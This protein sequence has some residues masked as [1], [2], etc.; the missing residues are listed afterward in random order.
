MKM[1]FLGKTGLQVSELCLGTGNF[2]ALGIYKKAGDIGQKE[3]DDIVSMALHSGINFFNTSEAYSDGRAEETLGKAL[4][5]RRKEAIVITKVHPTRSPGPNDGG[6]S[7]KHI[8]EGCEASLKRLKTDYVDLYQLHGFDPNTPIEV[9]LRALD[10]LVREGK[11]RYI[12]CSNFKGWQLMKSLAI[13]R[14]SGWES[15]ATLEAMY[16]LLSRELEYELIPACLDQ[17]IAILAFSPLHGGFLSGKYR[18]G[19]AWPAETRFDKFES[20]GAWPV[21]QE[22]LFKIVEELD[23]IAKNCS[24]SISQV[25]LNYLLRKSGI[26]S[27]IIGVRTLKQLEE[28]INATDWQMAPEDV[29]K[30]DGISAPVRKYP[31]SIFDAKTGKSE[32]T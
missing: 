17:G 3:A 12:G 18:R 2:S 28:N 31:Y 14:E 16:S 1:R 5:V 21:D 15:F 20:A 11:V 7:R 9:T 10:D 6:L 19:R 13:S 29:V 30:L 27:L 8:I 24:V 25:A 32:S 26:N 4:G 22:I 23:R